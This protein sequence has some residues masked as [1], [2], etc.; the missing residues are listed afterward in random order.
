MQWLAPSELRIGLGAMP[1]STDTD[2]DPGCARAT[3]SAA[4]A[5]GITVFDTARAY[6]RDDALRGHNER[7]LAG[8]LRE[9]GAAR[10]ARIVTKP[11]SCP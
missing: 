7:L 11:A 3:V 1:L 2:R 5:A 4:V 10:T 9:A 8:A 6:G